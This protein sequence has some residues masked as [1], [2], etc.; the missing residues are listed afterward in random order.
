V[1]PMIGEPMIWV[2]ILSRHHDVLHRHRC[3][4]DEIRIGRAY[5][6][7]V[8]LDDPAVAPHHLRLA[9]DE[10]GGWV[11]EDLGS[12]NG[13]YP[14]RGKE[15]QAHLAIDGD[16]LFRIGKTLLRL[17]PVDYPV[18]PEQIVRRL[19][20]LWPPALACAAGIVAIE[21]G[22]SFLAE[23]GEPRP[24]AYL[25]Q[26]RFV[27]IAIFVWIGVWAILC[28]VFT[29]FAQF[30]R[31]ALIALAGL[32]SY[33][34]FDEIV[35]LAGFALS[36]PGILSEEYIAF[37]IVLGFVA[38]LHMGLILPRRRGMTGIA[39]ATLAGL[40]IV[41][42]SLADSDMHRSSDPPPEQGR[43]YPPFLHVMPAQSETRFFDD[44]AR[45]QATLQ[46]NRA[47]EDR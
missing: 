16:R 5:D 20:P 17:R 29:G 32:L 36:V 1:E 47:D 44:V 27:G 31:H 11:A 30:E 6:N 15:R 7:D 22:S 23:T 45:L 19:V 42:E 2:E 33:S 40:A 43:L 25:G 3:A 46:A 28:R 13:L 12:V 26:L 35:K 4:G 34:M 18:V 37:W 8:I 38:I 39:A 41:A 14:E 10:Q 21:L 9:R 24:L